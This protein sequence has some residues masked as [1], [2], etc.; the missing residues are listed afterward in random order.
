MAEKSSNDKLTANGLNSYTTLGHQY[1]ID[2][3]LTN[4]ELDDRV[5][6]LAG[7]YL[8]DQSQEESEQQARPSDMVENVG[9]KRSAVAEM[10][11]A[12]YIFLLS[13]P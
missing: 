4:E 3:G 12:S 1:E 8:G 13:P 11:E 9:I 5:V 2:S 10:I 6:A 7:E